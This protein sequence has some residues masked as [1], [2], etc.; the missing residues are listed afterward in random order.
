MN[1][2][3]NQY[4]I[5]RQNLD[6]EMFHFYKVLRVIVNSVKFFEVL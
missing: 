6:S 3:V 2:V 4:R 5:K 1:V